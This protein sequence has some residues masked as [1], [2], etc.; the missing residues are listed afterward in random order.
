MEG[1][2]FCDVGMIP[3]APRIVLDVSRVTRINHESDFLW[4]AAIFRD[5]RE[6]VVR[7]HGAGD[8]MIPLLGHG[9]VPS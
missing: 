6:W 3:V 5:V 4:Q 7:Y 2:Y 1:Q 8:F 9:I